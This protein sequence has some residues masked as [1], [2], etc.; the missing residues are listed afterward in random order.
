MYVDSDGLLSQ[1][2]KSFSDEMEKVDSFIHQL[3]TCVQKADESGEIPNEIWSFAPLNLL[4]RINLPLEEGGL[5]IGAT[6]LRR[7]VLFEAMGRVSAGLCISLPG[8]GLS[9]PPVNA[10]GT[11]EQKR[12]FF[13]HFRLQTDRP[14][15]GAFAITEPSCGS[16]AVSLKT[17]AKQTSNGYVLNG[18]KCFITNGARADVIVVFAT[19]DSSKGRFGIR[20]FLVEKGN[21]G[22]CVDRKENMLGLRPSQ[23]ASLSFRDCHVLSSAMLGHNGSRGPLIDAFTGAQKAWDFM[24]PC[25]SAVIC[26]SMAQIVEDTIA[27]VHKDNSL[28][29]RREKNSII[30]ELEILKFRIRSSW[31]L[32]LQAASVFDEGKPASLFASMAKAQAA[33]IAQKVGPTLLRIYGKTGIESGSPI[34]RFWRD[35]KAYDILEGT[36]DMQR[37]MIARAWSVQHNG[38][39]A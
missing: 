15:W 24:R 37:L 35:S 9:F 28:L 14:V 21:P 33:T 5:H 11:P 2:R 36:G 25:L 4:N 26:G 32:T 12:I 31:L 23:L 39:V 18:E 8:P 22:F 19:I 7:T 17:S 30:S 13:D 29:L 6:A 27:D 34:E 3:P 16:D 38:R 10:L 1:M 20:A